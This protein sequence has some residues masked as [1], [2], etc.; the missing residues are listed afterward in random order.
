[1]A[2][3]KSVQ[4]RFVG[5]PS[6]PGEAVPDV[7]DAYGTTFEAGKFSEVS[8]EFADK[9]AGNSHFEVKGAKKEAPREETG[10]STAEFAARV[11]AITDREGLEAMLDAEKRPAAKATL[12][13]RLAALPEAPV[14]A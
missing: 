12:E 5:D 11:N 6:Q 9:V 14:A 13:R 1:M 4:A 3:A 10:E 8:G 7:M 2:E